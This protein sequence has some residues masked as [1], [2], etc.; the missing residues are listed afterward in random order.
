MA[1]QCDVYVN[2]NLS[3][4]IGVTRYCLPGDNSDLDLSIAGGE[5]D[6]VLLVR[7]QSYLRITLPNGTSSANCPFSVSNEDL[8]SWTTG[9]DHWTV[10]IKPNSVPPD[11]PT[12]VNIELGDPGS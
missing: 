5:E 3:E 10:E 2:N 11:T 7:T 12:T 4:T 8:L 9:D 1:D 6:N